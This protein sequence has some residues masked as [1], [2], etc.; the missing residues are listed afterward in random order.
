ML[1]RQ[2]IKVIPKNLC[3]YTQIKHLFKPHQRR[4]FFQQLGINKKPLQLAKVQRIRRYTVL[5]PKL[6][7]YNTPIL[8]KGLGPL[9]KSGQKTCKS[10]QPQMYFPD[11]RAVILRNSHQ[12]QGAQDLAS[13]SQTESQPK[14]GS[15][16]QPLMRRFQ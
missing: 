11:N 6:N 7:I 3:L 10:Q 9:W 14:K 4:F 1:K 8:L 13:L 16:S 2:N 12:R 5:S 15:Q